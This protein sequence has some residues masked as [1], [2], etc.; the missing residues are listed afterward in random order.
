MC[1]CDYDMPFLLI[2]T[3]YCTLIDNECFVKSQFDQGT[4][5]ATEVGFGLNLC[6]TFWKRHLRI[7]GK[8]GL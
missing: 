6:G 1:D 5:S 8:R 7:I 2:I 4:L 3:M